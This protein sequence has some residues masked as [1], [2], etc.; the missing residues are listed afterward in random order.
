[1]YPINGSLNTNKNVST[2]DPGALDDSESTDGP[3]PIEDFG[4]I[5]EVKVGSKA[6]NN[7]DVVT[8]VIAK[9]EDGARIMRE[10]HLK[11]VEANNNT[12]YTDIDWNNKEIYKIFCYSQTLSVLLLGNDLKYSFVL[13]IEK[14]T[15]LQITQY[16]WDLIN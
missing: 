13:N 3:G 12:G 1:M 2:D 10:E 5:E 11:R 16:L 7:D 8:F 9:T 14:N 6:V 15:M 4:P